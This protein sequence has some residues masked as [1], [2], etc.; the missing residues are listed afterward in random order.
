M[1]KSKKRQRFHLSSKNFLIYVYDSINSNSKYLEIYRNKKFRIRHNKTITYE[2][3]KYICIG[4]KQ[5]T[6]YIMLQFSKQV[7]ITN[8]TF[9]NLNINH[10]TIYVNTTTIPN[11]D[12]FKSECIELD[13]YLDWGIYHSNCQKIIQ[14]SIAKQIVANKG[15]YVLALKKNHLKLYNAVEKLISNPE[16][17]RVIALHDA[18]DDSHGRTVRRRYFS[19]DA[20][21]VSMYTDG[22]DGIKTIIAVETISKR[23]KEAEIKAEWRFYLTNH[24]K[25]NLNLPHYVRNHWG[26][27]NKLHWI[28]DVHLNED[29]DKKAERNSARS[30]AV[31]KRMAL[32]IVRTKDTNPK[33]SV[34]RKLKRV[35][36]DDDVL[37]SMLV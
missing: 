23:K 19:F 34:R 6:K 5:N 2:G 16:T 18:F 12:K 15:N 27:E 20:S 7:Q 9:F 31:L 28:L 3:P 36:W 30:F 4:S 11:T 1:A 29:N 14:K 26:I 21:A 24:N 13:D 8:R 33:R 22:W 25:S 35:S 17:S 32:N 37:I 10:T